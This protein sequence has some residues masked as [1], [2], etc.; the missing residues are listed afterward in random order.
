M[1]KKGKQTKRE[2]IQPTNSKD[3]YEVIEVFPYKRMDGDYLVTKNDTY[4]AIYKVETKNIYDLSLAERYQVMD[5]LTN[6]CRLYVE[7]LC[8]LSM[9]FPSSTEVNQNYWREQFIQAQEQMNLER[10]E[11]AKNQVNVQMWVEKQLAN[12]EFYIFVY[13][14]NKTEL[15]EN[16]KRLIRNSSSDLAIKAVKADHVEKILFKLFNPNTE[17]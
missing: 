16:G 11:A 13:G 4:E 17:V 15:I 2:S 12:H 6:L 1:V 14:N 8:I 9:M 3:L 7:D 10:M 5:S